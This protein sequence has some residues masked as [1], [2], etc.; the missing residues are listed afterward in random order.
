MNLKNQR[1]MAASLLKC[2]VNRVWIDPLRMEDV[3]DAITRTDIQIQI[4]AGTIKAKQKKGI[5]RGR[6]RYYRGQ[7]KK[8]RGRG[9]GSRKGTSKARK[10][11]KERWIQTIR[12]IRER[13][14]ELRDEGKIDVS[15]YRKFYLQAKG[16]VFKSKS[17]LETHLRSGGYL[18]GD[19]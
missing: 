4:D 6:T 8:G 18:K 7:R 9:Q 11:K 15:T 16:G 12:P 10:P 17:H 2:G 13:L 14:R 19:E 5:S 3:A 1:R